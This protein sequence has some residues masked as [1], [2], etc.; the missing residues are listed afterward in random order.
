MNKNEV[1]KELNRSNVIA[2]YAKDLTSKQF[3]IF[4]DYSDL[5]ALYSTV[6]C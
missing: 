1:I 2:I 5:S 3:R 6:S 4:L